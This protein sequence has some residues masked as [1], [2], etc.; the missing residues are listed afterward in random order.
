MTDYPKPALCKLSTSCSSKPALCYSVPMSSCDRDAP[1]TSG[2]IQSSHTATVGVKNTLDWADEENN[3]IVLQGKDKDYAMSIN[4]DQNL[5]EQSDNAFEL[6][7]AEEEEANKSSED[8]N[9]NDK[10]INYARQSLLFSKIQ[11]LKRFE[12]K[13]VDAKDIPSL[14][15][16]AVADDKT[17]YP[18]RLGLP[19]V[20]AK[21]NIKIRT[22]MCQSVADFA[23]L[24]PF[25]KKS[26]DVI[27]CALIPGPRCAILTQS[28]LPEKEEKKSKQLLNGTDVYIESLTVKDFRCKGINFRAIPIAKV[29]PQVPD[30]N[31]GEGIYIASK[32]SISQPPINR[33]FR[34]Y[35][36]RVF[37]LLGQTNKVF[38]EVFNPDNA[39]VKSAKAT[40]KEKELS[41]GKIVNNVFADQPRNPQSSWT[42]KTY[43]AMLKTLIEEQKSE[44]AEEKERDEQ[45]EEEEDDKEE[46]KER[47]EE[48]TTKEDKEIEAKKGRRGR[49]RR[50]EKAK[51]TDDSDVFWDAV[52]S[53]FSKTYADKIKAALKKACVISVSSDEKDVSKIVSPYDKARLSDAFILSF[54]SQWTR[55]QPN[56]PII[57]DTELGE[58]VKRLD[59]LAMEIWDTVE[60]NKDWRLLINRFDEHGVPFV[61]LIDPRANTPR[62]DCGQAHAM[63]LQRIKQEITTHSDSAQTTS[64]SSSSSISSTSSESLTPEKPQMKSNDTEIYRSDNVLASLLCTRGK[65]RDWPLLMN[66]GIGTEEIPKSPVYV[67]NTVRQHLNTKSRQANTQDETF[68]LLRDVWLVM[69]KW[70]LFHYGLEG[71]MKP[72]AN[73]FQDNFDLMRAASRKAAFDNQDVVPIYIPE[74]P[75]C[76]LPNTVEMLTMQRDAKFR[77]QLVDSHIISDETDW[78]K[79]SIVH[80]TDNQNKAV[81]VLVTMRQIKSVIDHMKTETLCSQK[82][83]LSSVQLLLLAPNAAHACEEERSASSTSMLE[84]SHCEPSQQVEVQAELELECYGEC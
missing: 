9:G 59:A 63:A 78:R 14:F 64:S 40:K 18:N 15:R 12:N 32:G 56:E 1:A 24:Y 81:A 83:P 17:V 65:R 55:F 61:P 67:S 68:N 8:Q 28:Q 2:R 54:E 47:I 33:E 41:L 10:D 38:A 69:I 50:P 6:F 48:T 66:C 57:S 7:R 43:K 37:K 72:I 45:H 46:K 26:K 36:D 79:A 74:S 5:K 39:V 75:A 29:E 44:E 82:V 80:E 25:E 35:L 11:T 42:L 21:L 71:Y 73:R 76:Y 58:S 51:K 53:S 22:A 30:L 52:P 31:N 23:K 70:S 20:P 13:Q 77:K 27:A 34:S 84:I 3:H 16:C 19:L 4:A 49:H 60:P 62:L